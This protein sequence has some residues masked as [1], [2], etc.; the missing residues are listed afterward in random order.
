MS[1][2]HTPQLAEIQAAYEAESKAVLRQVERDFAEQRTQIVWAILKPTPLQ[3]HNPEELAQKLKLGALIGAVLCCT[4]WWA[5]DEFL[6]NH[7]LKQDLQQWYYILFGVYA[8]SGFTPFLFPTNKLFPFAN[9]PNYSAT[10][11]HLDLL[12]ETVTIFSPNQ[13]YP[14]TY[15]FHSKSLFPKRKLPAFRLPETEQN[16]YRRLA[17]KLQRKISDLTGLVFEEK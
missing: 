17:E 16:E 1:V 15:S 12:R 10:Y 7:Q 14:T 9:K 4:A 5:M 8:L 13:Q 3:A 2:N 11:I 6:L